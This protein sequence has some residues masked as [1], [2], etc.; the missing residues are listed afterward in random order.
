MNGLK[1]TALSR[2]HAKRLIIWPLR[3]AT[4]AI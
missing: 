2:N 1:Q 4:R 3:Q